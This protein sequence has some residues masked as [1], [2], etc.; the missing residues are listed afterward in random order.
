MI[1][2]FNS[3][4]IYL[5]GL[6]ITLMLA[7]LYS[8]LELKLKIANIFWV[9]LIC[10]PLSI[11]AGIRTDVGTDYVN[12]VRIFGDIQ[13]LTLFECLTHSYLDIG[14][15]TVVRLLWY[16][17]D[18]VKLIFFVL[19]F[20]TLFIAFKTFAKRRDEMSIV[21]FALMYYLIMYHYSLNILRQ[22]LAMSMI[23]WAL[24]LMIDR[25]Y[26]K[27]TIVCV[28]TMLIHNTAVL[29]LL[30]LAVV[31]MFNT[32]KQKA[33]LA[34]GQMSG[35]RI[36]YYCLVLVSVLIIPTVLNILMKLPF[37]KEYSKHIISDAS[38]GLGRFFYFVILFAPL[39]LIWKTVES[40]EK[41]FSLFHVALLYLPVSF[42][43]YYFN[44]ASRMN[45]Y[46][47][48]VFIIIFPTPFI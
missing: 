17:T 21:L 1:A 47:T 3:I 26:V 46:T 41:L 16:I 32:K 9:A 34:Q 14:F 40:D 2:D 39:I 29:G 24:D 6:M 28:V 45:L 43:G 8:R 4:V 42:A 10:L 44:W 25:K 31:V 15:A 5:G 48:S 33:K 35:L 22:C 37:L 13:E 30:F 27:G 19:T 36:V 18:S 12:Y 7:A 20:A 11:I 38:V 23:M